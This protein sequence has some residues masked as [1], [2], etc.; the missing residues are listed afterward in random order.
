M[1]RALG[2]IALLWTVLV[3]GCG[4]PPMVAETADVELEGWASD[5][6]VTFHWDVQ[7]TLSQHDLILDLR[8]AST[9]SYSNLYLFLTYRFPNG[10]SRVDTV[11]CTLADELGRWRGSGFGD[12]VDQRFML[13][14]GIQFPLRGRYGLQVV[15]G[16]RQDPIEGVANVG[17]RLEKRTTSNP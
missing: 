1:N 9:Y 2:V 11:E 6:A 8:H 12:L 15:H 13:Q 3:A 7:D 5:S 17:I 4:A 14:P 10:K 16:M